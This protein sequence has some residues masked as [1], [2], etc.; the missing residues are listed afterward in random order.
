MDPQEITRLAKHLRQSGDKVLNSNFKLTLSGG[1]R[2]VNAM[3]NLKIK[4]SFDVTGGLLR[5]LNDSFSLIAD[6][7]EICPPQAFQVVKPN[8][9]KSDAFR[10]LQFI[11]DFV[12]KTRILRLTNFQNDDFDG[13]V[14]VSKFRC[15]RILEIKRIGIQRVIGLQ[16]LRPYLLEITCNR[17]IE[18]VKDIISHCGGD[19]CIGFKWDN[20]TTADFSYNLLTTINCSLDF[21]PSLQHLNLS[22]NQIVSVDAIKWLPNLKTVNLGFNRLKY[23]PT[24]QFEATRRLQTLILASNFIED[25]T[26][27]QLLIHFNVSSEDR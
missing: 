2:H 18:S 3:F 20:L 12:Q 16:R 17:S 1:S 22:H 5:A 14:D 10:D 8:N 7:N 15:L 27:S 21:A 9:S 24:F 23:I 6:E 11:H 26:G 25:I 13:V 19:N 4:F